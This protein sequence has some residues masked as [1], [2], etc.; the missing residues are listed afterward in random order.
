VYFNVKLRLV[1]NIT[2]LGDGIDTTTILGGF[3]IRDLENITFK[4]MTVTN[5]IS[6]CSGINMINT[7][8]E[9]MNVALKGNDYGGL[10]MP[11][12]FSS[13]N[14]V[15][16]TR[17]EF[18]GSCYGAY[19]RGSPGTSATF[20]DCVFN[21]N[22]L[23]GIAAVNNGTVVHL[24][25]E[26]TAVHSNDRSG[27]AAWNS[28]KIVIHLPSHHNTFYNNGDEDRYTDSGGTITNVVD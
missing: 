6:G 11:S 27:I 26:A 22:S 24:H 25:G 17:C 28:G 19:V 3:G 9:L 7:K 18:S 2:F 13:V 20:N 16:A 4:N 8:V 23:R 1:S 15:V 10:Y 5:T 21:A 12:M 14:T